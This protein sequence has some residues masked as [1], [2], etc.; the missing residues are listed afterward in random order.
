MDTIVAVTVVIVL[1]FLLLLLVGVVVVVLVL[2]RCRHQHTTKEE[3]SHTSSQTHTHPVVSL[4]EET[5]Q[6]Q[7][8]SEHQVT[9]PSNA[10]SSLTDQSGKEGA[11]SHKGNTEIQEYAVL[12]PGEQPLRKKSSGKK[13]VNLAVRDP[14]GHQEEQ[15]QEYSTLYHG[16]KPIQSASGKG[17][18]SF[19]DTVEQ[20]HLVKTKHG[21]GK[22]L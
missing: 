4:C 16:E 10:Y 7:H 19:Y 11:K 17:D 8:V 18:T 12:H 3:A 2:W 14:A 15:S 22:I 20:K 13:E 21:K 5:G 9:D 1:F 6:V